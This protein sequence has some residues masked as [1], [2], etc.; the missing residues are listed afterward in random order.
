MKVSSDMQEVE[1][2]ELGNWLI[3]LGVV[4]RKEE[5]KLT[6]RSLAMFHRWYEGRS[7]KRLS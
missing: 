4:M 3:L 5:S 7:A 1:L 6:L 2:T